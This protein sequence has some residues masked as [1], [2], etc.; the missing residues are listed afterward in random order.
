MIPHS[1]GYKPLA[2]PITPLQRVLL[3]LSGAPTMLFLAGA[4]VQT[5]IVS[6]IHNWPRLDSNQRHTLLGLLYQLS[7]EVMAERGIY[8]LRLSPL[9]QLRFA[10]VVLGTGFEPVTSP[11]VLNTRLALVKSLILSNERAMT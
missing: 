11:L 5:C 9:P 10:R 2:L 7:Y 4:N 8:I 6:R 1:S 3:R